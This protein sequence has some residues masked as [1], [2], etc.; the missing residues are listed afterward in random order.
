MHVATTDE[1]SILVGCLI[2]PYI[3]FHYKSYVPTKTVSNKLCI[4]YYICKIVQ[5][6]YVQNSTSTINK[7]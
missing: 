7:K 5:V 6:Q 1:I 4:V 3:H 2:H